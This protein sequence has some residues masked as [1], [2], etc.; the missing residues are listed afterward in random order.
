MGGCAINDTRRFGRN[1]RPVSSRGHRFCS[2]VRRPGPVVSP[3]LLPGPYPRHRRSSSSSSSSRSP[4]RP[5]L[6]NDAYLD[7]SPNLPPPDDDASL[8]PI[9]TAANDDGGPDDGASLSG[10]IGTTRP[11]A[12]HLVRGDDDSSGRMVIGSALMKILL[13]QRIPFLHRSFLSRQ[14]KKS[15]S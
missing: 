11:V 15:L 2:F 1:G 12:H 13:S 7:G 14:S 3:R 6:W 5:S 8:L 4:T 10:G 9:S